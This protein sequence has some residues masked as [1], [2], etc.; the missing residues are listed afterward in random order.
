MDKAKQGVKRRDEERSR[1]WPGQVCAYRP[2]LEIAAGEQLLAFGAVA[3]RRSLRVP[4]AASPAADRPAT[5]RGRFPEAE[6]S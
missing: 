6:A 4:L 5:V 3:G 2:L 1:R